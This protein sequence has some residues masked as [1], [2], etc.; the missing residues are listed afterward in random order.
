MSSAIDMFKEGDIN[1]YDKY[2]LFSFVK[3]KYFILFIDI[4]KYK[5][6]SFFF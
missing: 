5:S 6:G 4:K 3:N 1:F 2:D